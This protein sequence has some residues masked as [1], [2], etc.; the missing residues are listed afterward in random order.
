[1]FGRETLR[2]GD[3]TQLSDTLPT[4]PTCPSRRELKDFID[5]LFPLG[6]TLFDAGDQQ[7]I[8]GC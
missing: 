7:L 8:D 4:I 6:G 5:R 2:F 1:M 3:F